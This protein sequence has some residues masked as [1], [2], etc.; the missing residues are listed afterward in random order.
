MQIKGVAA[1]GLAGQFLGGRHV[2]ARSDLFVQGQYVAH[3]QH[4][5]RMAAG[6]KQFQAVQFFAGTRELD[7]AGREL[8]HC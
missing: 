2:D 8:S 3:A 1:L 7:G 4:A 5:L 6:V